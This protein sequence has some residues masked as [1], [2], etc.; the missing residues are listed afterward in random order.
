VGRCTHVDASALRF[1]ACMLACALLQGAH[2]LDTPLLQHSPH[3]GMLACAR[4]WRL[5]H[6]ARARAMQRLQRSATVLMCCESVMPAGMFGL[7]W[8][9]VAAL[10]DTKTGD[11][12][13]MKV[14]GGELVVQVGAPPSGCG[15]LYCFAPCALADP[16]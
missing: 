2:T 16:P 9:V 11:D 4:A 15:V 3:C 8:A 14:N 7:T 1:S 12:G 6:H 13:I 10:K 5:Q